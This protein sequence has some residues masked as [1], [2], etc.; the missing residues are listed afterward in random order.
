MSVYK[1]VYDTDIIMYILESGLML[2]RIY[3]KTKKEYDTEATAKQIRDSISEKS[4]VDIPGFTVNEIVELK[5]EINEKSLDFLKSALI[6]RNCESASSKRGPIDTTFTVMRRYGRSDERA[7]EIIDILK[8]CNCDTVSVRTGI[9]YCFE[10]KFTQREYKTVSS[11]L[12]NPVTEVVPSE[13]ESADMVPTENGIA[14]GFNTAQYTELAE[15]KEK[16]SLELDIDDM[17]SI[18]NY[19]LS[20][21]R[22]P[23]FAEL[24]IIDRFFSEAFRHIAFETILDTV[25]IFDPNAKSAWNNYRALSKSKTASLSDMYRVASERI[26]HDTDVNISD[27]IRGVKIKN[28]S[29]RDLMLSLR[30]G[31]RNTSATAEP[32]SGA[33]YCLGTN[34]LG[35]F[36]RLGDAYDSYRVSGTHNTDSST[37]RTEKAIMGYSELAAKT[38]VPC[39]R[40]IQLTGDAFSDKK[41]EISAVLA[42]SDLDDLLRLSASKSEP[43]DVIFLLGGKTGKDGAQCSNL[44]DAEESDSGETHED[45]QGEHV[46]VSQPGILN[47]LRRLCTKPETIRLAR[48]I[49]QVGSGGIACAIGKIADGVSICAEKIPLKYDGLSVSE[50]M[51][52]ESSER[53]IAAVSPENT[54]EFRNLCNKENLSCTEIASV[55]NSERFT[56]TYNGKKIVSLTRDFLINGGTEKHLSAIVEKP[57]TAAQSEALKIARAPFEGVSAIKKLFSKDIKCDFEGAVKYACSELPPVQQDSSL[58]FDET[59][60]NNLIFPPF[61]EKVPS[62]SVR[63]LTRAGKKVTNGAKPLCSA[64]GCGIFPEISIADPYKGAY[65]SVTEATLKLA[66]SGYG[67]SHTFIALQEYLPEYRNN[68]KQFGIAVSSLLGAL[69]A[70]ISLGVS[71]LGGKLSMGNSSKAEKHSTVTAFAVCV[72]APENAITKDLK[73]AGHRVILLEPEYERSSILPTPESQKNIISVFTDMAKNR[74][75]SSSV[76]V[77]ARCP[78]TALLEMC[79]ASGLGFEIDAERTPEQLFDYRYGAI[80]AEIDDYAELPK[81]AVCLGRIT[82]N[83]ALSYHKSIISLTELLGNTEKI[84]RIT[85]IEVLP[86]KKDYLYLRNIS[87]EYGRV[88]TVCAEHVNVVIPVNSQSVEISNIRALFEAAGTEAEAGNIIKTECVP[89]DASEKSLSGLL[90]AIDR[91][92]ILYIPDCGGFSSFT[93]AVFSLPKVQEKLRTLRVR[94]GLVY[95]EGNGAE[96][97]IHSGLL[98]LDLERIGVCGNPLESSVNTVTHIRSVSALSP[99]MRLSEPDMIYDSILTGKRLR[100]TGDPEYITSL[101]Y[102]GRIAAQY[103]DENIP[104]SVSSVDAITSRDGHVFAQ[105]SRPERLISAGKH[106]ILPTLLSAAGY[107]NTDKDTEKI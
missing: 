105:V 59:T 76:T 62:A 16:Y 80:L 21:S 15:F 77:T 53:M 24:N 9:E 92:D 44:P 4:G 41:L 101:A 49:Y 88:K 48:V 75:I 100:I 47:A 33:A 87:D 67:S 70:Q 40:S 18:Q 34:L 23:T 30:I 83:F 10:R 50:I 22:E 36:S 14:Y 2:N 69:E 79:R 1:T 84:S 78:I 56:V 43:G 26:K 74:K 73:K 12:R 37:F 54:A 63:Y 99:F 104:G 28:D 94:G 13:K 85:S 98:E 95:G 35:T 6:S 29:G 11:Y 82:E 60:G 20:E 31:N 3:L 89:Y 46:P 38:G 68:S 5:G 61:S 102:E 25:D 55:N 106:R 72:G 71:S 65:L 64:L 103:S 42:T 27:R 90:S 86:E 81:D 91:A 66:V 8:L 39:S 96:A 52:S 97:L 93:C 51:L 58:R 17:M 45:I 32:Y 107:F 57:E 19:F 7:G